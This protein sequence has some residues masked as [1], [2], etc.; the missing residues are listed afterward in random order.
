MKH[1]VITTA[2]LLS[3]S[4]MVHGD[5]S[6]QETA[7]RQLVVVTATDWNA[8]TGR[9]YTFEKMGSQWVPAGV[10]GKVNLGI[11]GLAWGLGLHPDQ[12]GLYKQEG[13]NK[14]PA[15]V[16]ELG[17]A[18]GKYDDV[19]TGLDYQP[20]DEGHYCIDNEASP[21]YNQIVHVN[22]VGEDA[23]KESTEP[24][25]RDIHAGDH[26]YDKGIIIRHNPESIAGKGCCVFI[27]LWRSADKPSAGCTTMEESQLDSL[28][29]W[30][31]KDSKPLFVVL[32]EKEYQENQPLWTLPVL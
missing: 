16:F 13:D 32:P 6:L 3:I 23:A 14:A 31:D 17:T 18:F 4:L 29:A 19:N 11:N 7:S 2:L 10:R 28:L 1:T 15:G 25:R 22:D 27:H 24:M 30:L 12:T 8:T 26:L 20:Q 5:F 21:F 9:L